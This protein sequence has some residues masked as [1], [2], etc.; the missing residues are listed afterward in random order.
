VKT[1]EINTTNTDSKYWEEILGRE[2]LSVKQLGLDDSEIV[3][4]PIVLE[5]RVTRKKS[6]NNKDFEQLRTKMDKDDP[7]ISGGHQ[8]KKIRTRKK[9]VPLWAT[10]NVETRKLLLRAFPKLKTSPLQRKRAG[11]WAA[12][13]TMFY[14]MNMANSQIAAE[15]KTKRSTIDLILQRIRWCAK[16]GYRGHKR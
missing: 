2:T 11:R 8:I 9:D 3:E 10:N 4:S 5:P 15:L 6:N 14:R 7:F 16:G 1:A 12:V 13:I